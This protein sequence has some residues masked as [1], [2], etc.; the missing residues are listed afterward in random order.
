MVD[1]G[2]TAIG[3]I[4][5]STEEQADSR[6]GLDAQRAA[7]RTETERRGW[8]LVDIVEDA[9]FSGKDLHRPG[10]AT[11][12]EAIRSGRADTLVVA[13][14]DRLGRSLLDLAGLIELASRQRSSLVA[15][16]IG[17]RWTEP[18]ARV[19]PGPMAHQYQASGHRRSRDSRRP[20]VTA[21]LRL[22]ARLTIGAI[23]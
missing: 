15:L 12:M 19:V 10:M 9:G 21:S 8:H 23:A 1:S 11:V 20:A 16:D 4:R 13:R 6:L 14:L 7:I 17:G 5:V 22:T 18:T 3:Y 2:T